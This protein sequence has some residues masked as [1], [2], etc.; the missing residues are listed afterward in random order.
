MLPPKVVQVKHRWK[1]KR[2]S[3][4][5][6]FWCTSMQLLGCCFTNYAQRPGYTGLNL[7]H[8][9]RSRRGENFQSCREGG[10]INSTVASL[11]SFIKCL[12]ILPIPALIN[13]LHLSSLP[14]HTL[15]QLSQH[16]HTPF[17]S[18]PQDSVCVWVCIQHWSFVHRVLTQMSLSPKMEIFLNKGTVDDIFQHNQISLFWNK[19]VHAFILWDMCRHVHVSSKWSCMN[20]Q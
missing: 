10:G 6:C 16:P 20:E 19:T 3:L 11:H 17:M 8:T 7:I 9:W 13:L 15:S 12:T 4:F 5:S 18:P 1:M 14:P 2:S